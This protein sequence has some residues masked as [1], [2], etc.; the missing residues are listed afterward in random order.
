MSTEL[1]DLKKGSRLAKGLFVGSFAI[2]AV[3]NFAVA[4]ADPAA[5][6]SILGP[7]G[8]GAAHVMY[9]TGLLV[10]EL[11]LTRVPRTGNHVLDAL[12]YAAAI[13][14]AWYAFE[15]S[16][17]ALEALG[18]RL[19]YIIDG[20]LLIAGLTDVSLARAIATVKE[21]SERQAAI[22]E[23]QA[24]QRADAVNAE[25]PKATRKRAASKSTGASPRA[26]RHRGPTAEQL[27]AALREQ[28]NLTQAALAERF[29]TSESTVSRRLST[30]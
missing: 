26:T 10:A 12:R 5:S 8:K 7:W 1:S 30:S 3:A 18:D 24:A 20:T 9:P 25:R 4:F 17:E 11:L 16:F 29:G 19:A 2:S 23:A 14:V 15:G 13:G 21:T 28:P 22:D 27:R 6:T